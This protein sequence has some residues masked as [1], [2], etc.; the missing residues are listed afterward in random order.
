MSIRKILLI[1][2]IPL[3]FLSVIITSLVSNFYIDNYFESYILADYNKKIEDMKNVSVQILEGKAIHPM[4]LNYFFNDSV[5]KVEL[6]DSGGHVILN[7]SNMSEHMQMM[8]G[9]NIGRG[10]NA[11]MY[12]GI[13]DYPI[14]DKGETLGLLRVYKNA[15]TTDT[16]AYGLL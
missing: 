8:R 14:V 9:R 16:A 5:L 15:P 4:D 10:N 7:Q 11:G 12:Y 13:E 1:I 2:V 6:Y 3:V